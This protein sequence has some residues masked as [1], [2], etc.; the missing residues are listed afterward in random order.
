MT[1]TS[2]DSS[3]SPPD[4]PVLFGLGA[5]LGDP[6]AQLR[7]AIRQLADG[8]IELVEVSQ[9][10]LTDPVGLSDQPDYLNLVVRGK[11]KL[12]V[13]AIHRLIGDIEARLGRQRREQNGPRLIDVDVLAYGELVLESPALTIPHPRLHERRFVLVP[14]VGV[15]SSWRHPRIGLPAAQLLEGLDDDLMVTPLGPLADEASD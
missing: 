13:Y 15:W 10:F 12:N 5:N 3:Y 2:V 14:L 7:S 4:I 11:T 1:S 9:L 8:G 6:P